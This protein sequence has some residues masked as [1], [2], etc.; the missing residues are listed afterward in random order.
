MKKPACS[1][2]FILFLL[3]SLCFGQ[4]WAKMMESPNVNVHDVQKAFYKWY[5]EYRKN[6]KE[7]EGK[8]EDASVE[9][10]KRWEHYMVPR[11]YPGGERYNPVQVANESEN[12][13]K[14]H[15]F[16]SPMA[17]TANWTYAGNTAVPPSDSYP[18]GGDGRV[19]RIRFF[20]GNP[21]IMYACTPSGG[22]W[23]STDGG[24][25]WATNTDNLGDLAVCDIAF[26]PKNSNI[27]YM[28]TG[29]NENPGSGTPMTIGVLKSTDGGNTWNAT[30]LKYSQSASGPYYM[31]INQLQINPDNPDIIWAASS[32]GL[33]KSADSGVTWKN[34]LN[35]D[36]RSLEFEPFH[37]SVMYAGDNSGIFYRSSDGGSTFTR[38]TS[39][40]PLADAARMSIGVSVADSNRVYVLAEDSA[41]W[42]LHGLYMSTDRGQTF[43][44]Q[45]SPSIGSPNILGYSNT[46]ND[47]GGFGWYSL[48]IAVS[49][50]NADSVFAGGV[51][52]WM[53]A[54]AGVNWSLVAQWYGSG[55]PYV[56]ADQHHIVFYPGSS[57]TLFSACD[58]GIFQSTDGGS[59]WNDL[60]NNLEIGQIYNIGLSALTP[61]LNVTG[62]Q[63]NGV[64]LSLPSWAQ[65]FGGD[66]E[67]CFIDYTNDNNLFV[68]DEDGALYSSTDGGTSFNN[69]AN[70]ITESGPWTTQWLQ[71]PQNPATL[72]A[73]FVNVWQS[74]NS[75]MSWTQMST[76][77]TS[78]ISA[79]AVAP[80]N[81]Q[82]IYAAQGDSIFLSA[83]AGNTWT[84]INGTLPL[85]S[86]YLSAIAIDPTNPM[87]VWVTFSGYTA[88]AKVYSSVNGGS[89]WTNISTGLPNLPVNTI[90][91]NPGS[92]DGIYAGTD[93]GVYYR[94][95]T[96]NKW[97]SYNTGLPNVVIDDLKIY[98]PTNT[99][100]SATFGRGEWQTPT[101]TPAGINSVS[102][103]GNQVNVYPNPSTVNVQFECCLPDGSYSINITDI[104]GQNAYTNTIKVSGA[105]KGNID[106]TGYSPGVYIFSLRG[107][108][109][110]FEK[111][112]VIER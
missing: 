108:S 38:I 55:A 63:D 8:G 36:I 81:D 35:D 10:F 27:I 5:S 83:D 2:F 60:S 30:G 41:N 93:L 85:K 104:L 57:S 25:T 109:S 110:S 88:T 6:G 14:A 37:T 48:P 103:N 61:G 39:G 29:D 49:P 84:L 28:G 106:I 50:T 42:D 24:S 20:P 4:D 26:D 99:L 46:G 7:N 68:S 98:S 101:Y 13:R 9:L 58:G 34:M 56:H 90:V 64:N 45:A 95:T 53:S 86:N 89:T 33:W 67:V 97:I 17:T 3:S 71:D 78:S 65:V 54:N 52:L 92:P 43:Q 94:D 80:S 19:D 105:Y 72:Y 32:F 44:L 62:W 75:G 23:K 15:S 47:S 40:L 87:K 66:G 1:F 11:T 102:S 100:V 76:W 22:L 59:T 82:Y 70:G 107:A 12:Y 79:L 51:N 111:R 18:E 112:V 21:N 96:L 74:A 16:N 73:G 77:G 69:A 31:V 91:Y